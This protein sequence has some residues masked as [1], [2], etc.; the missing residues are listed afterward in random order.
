VK[1]IWVWLLGVPAALPLT[2]IQTF[3]TRVPVLVV[4]VTIGVTI[5]RRDSFD[6]NAEKIVRFLLEEWEDVG[7]H[8]DNLRQEVGVADFQ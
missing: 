4:V 5:E 1:N 7:M 3:K 8:F 6:A 2:E